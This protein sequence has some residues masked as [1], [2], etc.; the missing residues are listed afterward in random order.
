MKLLS[1]LSL[2]P[3][4]GCFEFTN[5]I[6]P[7]ANSNSMSGIN[8]TP[9]PSAC[10]PTQVTVALLTGLAS[11]TRNNPTLVQAT[12]TFPNSSCTIEAVAWTVSPSGACTF[13]NQVANLVTVRCDPADG[14]VDVDISA[15]VNGAVGQSTFRVGS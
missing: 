13:S 12:P 15:T 4:F 2:V 7:S 8:P 10:E 6:A 1:I 14:I 5:V 11:I 3:L 9:S